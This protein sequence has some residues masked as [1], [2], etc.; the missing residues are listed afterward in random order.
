MSDEKLNQMDFL[1]SH[2]FDQ[3]FIGK[4]YRRIHNQIEK[5]PK[6]FETNES[7]FDIS[8]LRKLEIGAGSGQHLI[9]Y[10]NKYGEYF[11]LDINSSGFEKILK[12]DFQGKIVFVDADVQSLP[13]EDQYFD[14]VIATCVLA[15]ISDPRKALMEILRVTK[16]NGSISLFISTDPSIFLRFVRF[17]SVHYVMRKLPIPYST[18]IRLAHRNPPSFVMTLCKLIFQHEVIKFRY[19]PFRLKFWNLSTHIIVHIWKKSIV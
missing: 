5:V 15:H 16:P 6:K 12:S 19:Y 7:K 3:S 14:R 11:A 17:V 2:R 10:P 8:N 18:Y 13:F 4:I 9:N 1:V